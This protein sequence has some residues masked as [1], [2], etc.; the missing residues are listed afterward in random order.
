M[1]FKQIDAWSVIGSTGNQYHLIRTDDGITCD[2]LGFTNHEFCK[3]VDALKDTLKPSIVEMRDALVKYETDW[4]MDNMDYSQLGLLFKDGFK[5]FD[6]FTNEE[7][8]RAY[9]DKFGRD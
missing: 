6:K 7:I 1:E 4:A 9:Y 2:C 3:H 5:G 8:E